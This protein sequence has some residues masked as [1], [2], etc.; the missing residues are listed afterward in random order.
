M[1][2]VARSLDEASLYLELQPCEVCGQ[3]ALRQQPGVTGGEVDGEPVTWL[4]TVCD[5]CG[6][7][8]R[9]AFRLPATSAPGFGG[10]EPS[11]HV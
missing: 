2:P 9:F 3:L 5:N 4:E 7:R 6:N 1:T 8:A 10:D 11:Q